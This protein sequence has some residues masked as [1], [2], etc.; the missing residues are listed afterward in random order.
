MHDIRTRGRPHWAT[1]V[2][3]LLV[4]GLSLGFRLAGIGDA[5]VAGRLEGG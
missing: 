3:I 4:L 2:G 5:I 1:V